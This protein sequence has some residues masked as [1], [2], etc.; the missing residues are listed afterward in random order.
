MQ[1]Q[2]LNTKILLSNQ[3]TQLKVFNYI[4]VSTF[5]KLNIILI[6]YFKLKKL[7]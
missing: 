4:R 1:S 2:S 6:L 5:I 3:M 7:K